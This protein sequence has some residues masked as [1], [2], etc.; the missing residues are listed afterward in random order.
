MERS[1]R[2]EG[3]DLLAGA[4][5]LAGEGVEHPRQDRMPHALLSAGNAFAS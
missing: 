4:I 5:G 1:D 3:R 2:R